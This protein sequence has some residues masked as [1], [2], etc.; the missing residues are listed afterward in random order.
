MCLV[1]S[2]QMLNRP[3]HVY[4]TLDGGMDSLMRGMLG[5]PIQQY[6][7]F[8]TAEVTVHLFADNPPHGLGTDL[9]SLNVQRG[10]DHGIPGQCTGLYWDAF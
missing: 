8:V 2:R 4:V 7:R 1:L 5:Q 10:R 6:D 9:V 3:R